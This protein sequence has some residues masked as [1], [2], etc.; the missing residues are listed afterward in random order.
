[1]TINLGLLQEVTEIRN[2]LCTTD[3]VMQI[4]AKY[5][6]EFQS[7][8]KLRDFSMQ[9]HVYPS[10]TPIAQPL[11]QIPSQIRAKV[12]HKIRE[13]EQLDI[14][15]RVK[16]PTPWVSLVAIPKPNGEVGV[17]V[18]MRQANQAIL[19]K[20]QQIPTLEETLQELNGAA[21]F[22]KLDLC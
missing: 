16:G 6:K 4:L 21:L 10:V 11:C 17:C 19:R 18:D 9:I 14:I 8:G 2:L 20:C 15:E 1:M 22:S 7:V 3:P 12:D 5:D 13:L